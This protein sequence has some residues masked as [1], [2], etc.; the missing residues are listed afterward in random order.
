MMPSTDQ[1]QTGG[2]GRGR[3]SRL[4]IVAGAG[5]LGLAALSSFLPGGGGQ[6]GGSPSSSYSYRPDGA[7]AWAELL[8]RFGRPVERLRGDLVPAVLDPAATV[9][10]LDA[11]GLTDNETEALG[12]FVRQG[13]HLVAGGAGADTLLEAVVDEPPLLAEEGARNASPVGTPPAPEVE[14]VR[15]VRAGRLG[16]WEVAGGLR[17]ILAGDLGRVIAV[18]GDSGSGRVVALADPSPVQNGFLAVEDNAAFALGLVG[19][20]DR[21]VLFAEGAHGYGESEGLA[22][23][24]RRWRLVLAGLGL[25]AGIWLYAR[26]RRFGPPEDEARPLPPPR[27][28]YVDAVAGTLARTRRPQEA[29][30]PVRRRAREL[31]ARRAALPPDAGPDDLYQAAIRL[32]VPA[33]EAAAAL[34]SPGPTEEATVLAAGRALARL[35]GGEQ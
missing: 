13:G 32:G 30:E 4:A 35:T 3:A 6:G 34:G 1:G 17:P 26:S 25:A 24:P 10:V 12:G 7:S 5:L 27:W 33:D 8:N 28:A 15:T 29:A 9:V 14:G 18:A 19:D 20:P 16:S 22:A 21:R 31:I 11:P 23:L 2:T